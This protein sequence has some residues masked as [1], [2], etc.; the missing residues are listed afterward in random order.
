MRPLCHIAAVGA[1]A[2]TLA[3]ATGRTKGDLAP[4][5][6]L[7]TAEVEAATR[8]RRLAL[9]IGIDHFADPFWPDLKYARKDARELGTVLGRPDVGAFDVVNI[10]ESPATREDVFAALAALE[11]KIERPDDVVVVY[12]STHGTL[13]PTPRGDLERILVLANTRRSELARTGLRVRDLEEAVAALPSKRSVLI[14]ATCHGGGGKSLLTPEAERVLAGLKGLPPLEQVSRAQLVLSAAAFGQAA[15]EDD[16]LEHDVYTYFLIDAL[17]QGADANGDGAI[18]A[19]EA[20]DYA[21]RRTWEYTEGRQIPAVTATVA[22]AD[23]IVL[24]GRAT[25]PG[26]PVVYSYRPGLE[27]FEVR[28][29]GRLKGAFPGA[30]VLDPGPRHLTVARGDEV[31]FDGEVDLRPGMRLSAES[32]LAEHRPKW[33]VALRGDLFGVVRPGGIAGLTT[34]AAGGSVSLRRTDLPLEG[35]D[36]A[37]DLGLARREGALGP[38]LRTTLEALRVGAGAALSWRPAWGRLW[39]GPHL[40]LVFL[41]RRLEGPDLD[42]TQRFGTVVP[43][44]FAGIAVDAGRFE[45]SIE[46]K[47]HYLP[48][49]VDERVESVAAGTLGAG[50]GVR[51]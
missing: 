35:L 31:V 19:T 12:V 29:G 40:S 37:L 10:L 1:L 33:S 42:E 51:F 30:V 4:V 43:G 36:L 26:L 28:A 11:K 8:P 16:A 34:A 18:S 20:H 45:V 13:A 24:A 17:I 32:L 38:A 46:A 39:A 6:G 44:A 7:S 14:L 22:G 25:R 9:L 15:R 27:G 2:S 3:C 5:E 48:L 50:V 41:A 49:V 47:L 21:R 23:P